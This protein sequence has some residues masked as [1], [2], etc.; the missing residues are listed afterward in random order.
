MDDIVSSVL[1]LL[2]LFSLSAFFS[3]SETAFTSLSKFK[4]EVD[5]KNGSLIATKLL[6]LTKNPK[7]FL[8]VLLVGN[9]IVNVSIA[10]FSTY[11]VVQTFKDESAVFFSSIVITIFLLLFGEIIP[12]A[13]SSVY[14]I[15]FAKF[16]YNI[17]K[18]FEVV[19]KPFVLIINLLTYPFLRKI[20][21]AKILHLT[22]EDLFHIIESSKE[23]GVL[24][25]DSSE[26]ISNAFEFKDTC[27]SEILTPRVDI[28]RI[29]GNT[30]LVDAIDL[31]I[32]A[33]FSRIPVIENSV[34]KIIGIAYLKDMIKILYHNKEK[35]NT[36]KIKDIM[37]KPLR[38]PED[39][40]INDLLIEMRKSQIQMAVVIDE[41]GG[42]AG[43]V[44]IEDILEEIVGE[45][46]DEYDEEQDTI[47][48]FKENVL[49]TTGRADIGEINSKLDIDLPESDYETIGG[50]IFNELGR[51]IKAGD[52]LLK[53]NVEIIVNEVEGMNI[54]KLTICKITEETE[55][56][57]EEE[58]K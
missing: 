47:I 46:R 7:R 40:K 28:F 45:I 31:S 20:S 48:E 37:R 22:E 57:H 10:S 6:E 21:N 44:T 41:Y 29:D 8:T 51:E 49:I 12:K 34:D 16:F 4:L 36:M 53:E 2:V 55:E 30:S 58:N 50:L 19:L 23:N 43:L 54:K 42:T 1:I 35:A 18:F 3:S 27:V 24:D 26:I 11:I 33:G 17:F 56:K 13:Y 5:S 9:N 52:K 15:Q 39:K 25:K 14:S 38:I 32:K